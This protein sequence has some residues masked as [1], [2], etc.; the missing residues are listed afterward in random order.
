MLLNTPPIKKTKKVTEITAKSA[1]GLPNLPLDHISLEIE[2]SFRYFPKSK[3]D[4][5]IANNPLTSFLIL[6]ATYKK[7]VLITYHPETKNSLED[8]NCIL[9]IFKLIK[10]KKN[11][12]FIF[13]NSNSD[14]KGLK[15]LKLVKSFCLKNTNCIHLGSLGHKKYLQLMSD[16]DLVLGNSSSG[17]IEASTLKIVALNIGARQAG[18][19]HS[20]NIINCKK[21]YKSLL[22]GFNKFSHINKSK[23]KKIFYKK[24]TSKNIFNVIKKYLFNIKKD[25][26]KEFYD[27]KK[28]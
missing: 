18:R 21:N 26:F 23:I 14:P 7:K 12:F 27:I 4:L 24:N 8:I 25:K 2:Y 20:N 22:K 15:I 13:T 3:R 16:V 6:I 17:I 5:T 19:L 10:K 1:I 28:K 9:N 11:F